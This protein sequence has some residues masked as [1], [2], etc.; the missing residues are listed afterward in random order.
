MSVVERVREAEQRI[1]PYV[2]ETVLERS[3]YFSTLGDADVYF[4]LENLQHTG[5]FKARGAL[6]KVLSLTDAELARK[7]DA[8]HWSEGIAK[9]RRKGHT[10]HTVLPSR[11]TS[12]TTR[13]HVRVHSAADVGVPEAAWASGS[14]WDGASGR[15]T[16]R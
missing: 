5:S 8:R 15:I 4:K 16:R 3:S 1:R 14:G 6:N 10:A 12:G 13:R 9:C 7:Y 2:R 11:S